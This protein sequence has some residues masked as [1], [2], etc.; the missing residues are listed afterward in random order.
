MSEAAKILPIKGGKIYGQI[1]Q[2]MSEI[3]S[4]GKDRRNAQQGYSFRGIDD[5]YNAVH[6]LL[7]K[8]KV[9]CAPQ[10]I[11]KER[12]D[13]QSK[14]GGGLI[15]TVLTVAFDFFA[16]DGSSV[17]VVTV[18]EGMDS[19]DKSANKA[20]S[21][22]QKYA[23]IQL[24][25]IP[26][27]E[28][29]DSEVESPQV[30]ALPGPG[31]AKPAAKAKAIDEPRTVDDEKAEA[32]SLAELADVIIPVGVNKNKRMGDTDLEALDGLAKFFDRELAA[33]KKL[34]PASHFFRPYLNSYLQ[35][36]AEF[37]GSGGYS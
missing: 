9:F 12:E 18:G 31:T 23:I 11:S 15:Y 19:G 13:R 14:S 10:V 4:V 32:M 29:V 37:E 33:G 34:T 1:A 5:I 36:G 21:G 3:G 27:E 20:M 16:D 30:A 17:R 6:P 35:K 22:A 24:F 8:H 26:T 7:V 28:G 25:A 2:I